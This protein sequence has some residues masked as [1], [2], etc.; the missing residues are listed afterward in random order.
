MRATNGPAR[1]RHAPEDFFDRPQPR[2]I[3]VYDAR[4]KLTTLA[5]VLTA[6]LSGAAL[7]TPAPSKPAP[8]PKKEAPPRAEAPAADVEKFLVW[9]DK[10]VDI[11]VVNKDDCTKM[12]TGLNAHIDSA[13]ALLDAA[14]EA[15]AKGQKLPDAARERMMKSAGKLMGAMQK[16]GND[17]GVQAA[18]QR[19]PRA[20]GSTKPAK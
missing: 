2:E 8:A 10:L 18:L 1:N 13:K 7:A 4:M 19:L 17:K 16:C 14:A 6:G 11:A 5:F 9:F 15:Q 12:A 3:R 20:G